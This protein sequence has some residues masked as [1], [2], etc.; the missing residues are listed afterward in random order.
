MQ[1][2][3][4]NDLIDKVLEE[5][6]WNQCSLNIT[7]SLDTYDESLEDINESLAKQLQSMDEDIVNET[8]KQKRKKKLKQRL[9]IACAILSLLV[10]VL[11]FTPLGKTILS[12][13]VG[14]YL[15][16]K[17]SYDGSENNLGNYQGGGEKEVLNQLPD[18]R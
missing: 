14:E 6:D 13:I 2:D 16:G 8:A 5:D 15:Y 18:V 11:V 12:N 1:D 17:L 7:N 4:S 10:A 3:N 9:G